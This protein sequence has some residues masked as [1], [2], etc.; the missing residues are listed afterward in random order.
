M[1]ASEALRR[2]RPVE[3]VCS[4]DGCCL[5][6]TKAVRRGERIGI[7]P[8]G[9]P[10]CADHAAAFHDLPDALALALQAGRTVH[11]GPRATRRKKGARGADTPEPV[12]NGSGSSR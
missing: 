5:E 10:V 6:A 9:L 1:N 7:G 8:C 2:H 12:I 3:Y 4:W 11:L